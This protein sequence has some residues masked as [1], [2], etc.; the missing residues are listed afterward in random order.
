M[1]LFSAMHLGN[2]SLRAQ[3]VGMQVTGQNIANANTPGY[4]REEVVFTPA[5]TQRLG[6]LLLGMGVEVTAVVQKI[7]LFLEQRLRSATSDRASSE[8]QHE[9]YH[10]LE[11]IQGELTE[12][13]LSTSLNKFF[14]SI[15]NVLN[16]PESIAVRNLA[17]LQGETLA[18]DIR[19]LRDQVG[20]VR[21]DL[22]RQIASLAPDINR[23]IKDIA[24]LN[25]RIV[26]MESGGVSPSDAVGL[27]D[28]RYQK[29]TELSELISI[30]VEEQSDGTVGIFVGGDYLVFHGEYRPVEAA[31]D[32]DGIG[33]RTTIQIDKTD[34]TL[35]LTGGKVD[36]L[37]KAR[38]NVLGDFMRRLDE[39]TATFISEF[40]KIYSSGQGLHGYSELTSEHVV[41]DVGAALDAAGLPF[42][43]VN[44]SLQ[45]LV[46][47]RQTGLTET[48]DVAVDLNGLDND[49]TLTDLVAALDA[50]DGL[51][52]TFTDGRV[53]LASETPDS[54]FA[55]A[56][57]TSG[58][59]AALGLG[60]FFTGKDAADIG[61]NAVVADDPATF[62]ASSEGFGAGTEN[63]VTLAQFK[64]LPLETAGG[65][66]LTNLYD[67]LT[68]QTT[69]AAAAARSVADG[70]RVFE[71]TLQ[72]QKQSISGVSLDEEA[73][74]MIVFQR[75]FQASAK[76]IATV[77]ELLDVLVDL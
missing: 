33:V 1:S 69:E 26:E 39:F 12:N 49:T 4:I 63:A 42:T 46:F 51:S 32:E 76:F 29:L 65:D 44:G 19:R 27:R 31:I 62:A 74:K 21:D 58:V 5:P 67:R 22:D 52:A 9:A 57:D 14:N 17:A 16:Q 11:A 13:D 40:N 75:A 36:G 48:S 47:N 23:L 70:F 38:D 66:T 30:R 73:V 60:T 55:F 3:T 2:N 6:N 61:L 25:V 24:R 43:P 59:L 7:D 34:S 53:S 35:D 20:D 77:S 41:A 72:G 68:S 45:V 50:I 64:D 18:A 54:Q 71:E 37:S 56:R 15:H 28:Q 10:Q 8:V